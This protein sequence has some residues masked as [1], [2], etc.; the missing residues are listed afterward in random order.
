MPI[1][2]LRNVVPHPDVTP[3]AASPTTYGALTP[4]WSRGATPTTAPTT[5]KS[6]SLAPLPCQPSAE[7]VTAARC[8]GMIVASSTQEIGALV[9]PPISTV[10]VRVFVLGGDDLGFWADV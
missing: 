4:I 3:D 6:N 8:G 10:R 9:V 5:G 2:P 7:K 1:L